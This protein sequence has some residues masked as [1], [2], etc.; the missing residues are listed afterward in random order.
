ML[1][2]RRFKLGLLFLK[3]DMLHVW[4]E[5]HLLSAKYHMQQRPV[6]LEKPVGF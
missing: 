6:L 1:H 3:S 4:L 5:A 2:Q